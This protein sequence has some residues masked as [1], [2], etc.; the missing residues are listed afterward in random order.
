MPPSNNETERDIRD[1]VVLQRKI[2]H[3]FVNAE[4]RRV[5]SI[6]QSFNM[7]CRKLG[8]VPWRCV[9]RMVENPDFNIFAAGHGLRGR[10]SRRM[11]SASRTDYTWTTSP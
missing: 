2:R 5:F 6:L 11:R 10:P 3:K 7:T 1:G 4:G 9:G 8:L